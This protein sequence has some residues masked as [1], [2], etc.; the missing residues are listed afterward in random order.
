[1]IS[2]QRPGLL[3]DDGGRNGQVRVVSYL[4][5]GLLITP[6]SHASSGKLRELGVMDGILF[7]IK[8]IKEW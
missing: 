4:V 3:D 8:A 2:S 6:G 7:A 1:M 5:T